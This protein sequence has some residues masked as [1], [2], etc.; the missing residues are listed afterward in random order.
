MPHTKIDCPEMN[1]VQAFIKALRPHIFG[2]RRLK[3]II[4][5]IL[6]TGLRRGEV[7]GLKVDDLDLNNMLLTVRAETSKSRRER[8]VPISPQVAK[9]VHRFIV[10]CADNWKSDWIFPTWTGDYLDPLNLDKSVERISK[11]TGISLKLHGLRHL[12]ATQFL[13]DTGNIALT[14]QL[15]GHTNISVTSRFYE[16]LNITDLQQA[17]AVASPIRSILSNKRIRKI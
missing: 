16:H 5:L 14:A 4:M 15:L 9:E 7:C 13:R 8:I 17:H 12:C 11:H 1:T 2:E 10:S 3:C 6:D